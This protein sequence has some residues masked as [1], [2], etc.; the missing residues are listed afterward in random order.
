[1]MISAGDPVL[2]DIRYI[3]RESGT[4]FLSFTPPL[5]RD[6]VLQILDALDPAALSIP[7]R[8][9][10]GRVQNRLNPR[11][12]FSDG[13]FSVNA[14]ITAAL[15]GRARTNTDIPWG[16]DYKEN[17]VFVSLPVDFFFADSF[18]LSFEPM[19]AS[20][21]FFYESAGSFWVNLPY[22]AK[23]F[24]MNIPLRAFGAAGG[25]WWNFQLGR[26]RVSFGTAFTGNLALSDTPD[27][28]DFARLSVFS[29]Y[30][31]YS[32]LIS[33]LP[34][35][36][37]ASLADPESY[38]A[39]DVSSTLNR[40]LYLHR[41]DF[42]LFRKLSLGITEAVI[43]GNA[44]LE[45]RYLN[46]L[47]V[48][49]SFFSW[50]D[51]PKWGAGDGDLS[52]SLFSLDIE[53]AIVPSLRWYG[54]MVMN[55][56]STPYE[57]KRW[58]D[59]QPPNGLGYLCGLEYT[60][61]LNAWGATFYGEFVYTDPFLYVLSSP[62]ASFIWMRR[63]S[64]IGSKGLR[65]RW[66]GHP[67]GR[68]ILLFTLGSGFFKGNL[69]YAADVSFIRRGENTLFWNWGVGPGFYDQH[70]PTGTAENQ[71]SAAF[72]VNWKPLACLTLTAYLSGTMVFNAKHIKEKQAYGMDMAFSA[73]FT[74]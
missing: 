71:L 15:G 6:E 68:D 49:H 8:E 56:F 28:Y 7:A 48:F 32:V 44:P 61:A 59:S 67:E 45:L 30:F 51:Y 42:R 9:A 4:S 66:M 54:Q 19:L 29:S 50:Q 62:F 1:M 69:S 16:Q 70:T 72:K 33:Q 10:Y 11:M 22:E 35:S 64:D 73:A 38:D 60:R 65:Y 27:Y 40:Y 24:D 43:I 63:L 58:P 17:P 26:D 2:E 47:A 23:R 36:L 74:Y 53:W 46:P 18:E 14:H 20:D 39:G 5:S 57:M 13:L 41:M 31:K 3:V 52:G 21:P 34:L 12:R 55:E 25:N 37:S